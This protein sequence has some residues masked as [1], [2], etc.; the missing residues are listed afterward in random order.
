MRVNSASHNDGA[1]QA[2]SAL[3]I[4]PLSGYVSSSLSNVRSDS[5]ST[6]SSLFFLFFSKS[7]LL[8]SILI[9]L[10]SSLPSPILLLF[11]ISH[12][13]A[14]HFPN[15]S[16][17][18]SFSS[19]STA[20]PSSSSSTAISLLLVS[21]LLFLLLLLLFHCNHHPSSSP[22]CP[23]YGQRLSVQS[24]AFGGQAS[25]VVNADGGR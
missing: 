1:V 8:L 18:L 22:S 5:S 14:P 17:P 15:L 16:I 25:F 7:L 11:L 23:A 21:L 3:S 20:F 6:I 4:Q 19:S 24:H 9:I 2:F 13:L 12:P 10:F